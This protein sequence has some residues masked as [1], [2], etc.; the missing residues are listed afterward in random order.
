MSTS[1]DD[2]AVTLQCCGTTK[3]GKQCRFTT[4]VWDRPGDR[5]RYFW[6]CARH[7][8]ECP[9]CSFATKGLL[10][11]RLQTQLAGRGLTCPSCF[12]EFDPRLD[13]IEHGEHCPV[14]GTGPRPGTF[15]WLFYNRP[16][17]I[18]EA[19][20][21]AHWEVDKGERFKEWRKQREQN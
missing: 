3:R 16:E 17:V 11:V 10:G 9:H 15:G 8:P 13:L 21:Y 6:V 12:C 7:A 18:I 19:A 5:D 1:H 14:W 2:K 4:V 20:E